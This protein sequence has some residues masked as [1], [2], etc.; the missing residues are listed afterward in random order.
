MDVYIYTHEH[1]IGIVTH[2][3]AN[4]SSKIVSLETT[5]LMCCGSALDW[6]KKRWNQQK[7]THIIQHPTNVL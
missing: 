2:T 6:K 3:C 1:N 4:E 7:R 5:I